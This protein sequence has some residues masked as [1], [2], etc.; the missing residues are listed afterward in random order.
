M[1]NLKTHKVAGIHE[2]IAAAH[3]TL[4]YL[5]PYSPELSPIELGWS[6]VKTTSARRRPGP[7]TRSPSL[8]L[9]PWRPSRQVTPVTGSLTVATVLLPTEMCYHYGHGGR[10]Q[11]P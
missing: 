2:A 8:G 11:A 7:R 5:L 4:R 6:K 3:T 10:S 9:R 1:D